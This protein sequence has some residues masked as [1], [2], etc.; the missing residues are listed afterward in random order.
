MLNQT[1]LWKNFEWNFCSNFHMILSMTHPIDFHL[2]CNII[3]YSPFKIYF[4][5]N[6]HKRFCIFLCKSSC[7][8]KN[9]SDHRRENYLQGTLEF[10]LEYCSHNICLAA[11]NE[12][13]KKEKAAQ[14]HTRFIRRLSSRS[15]DLYIWNRP[16][17][18]SVH[19][20]LVHSWHWSSKFLSML[21]LLKTFIFFQTYIQV[22]L[23]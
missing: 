19:M 18:L 10:Y 14:R 23:Q 2:D 6:H 12:K 21:I 7:S 4:Q 1:R 3:N 8:I 17:I 9:L 20:L 16:L 15:H 13:K 5:V 22:R 11:E